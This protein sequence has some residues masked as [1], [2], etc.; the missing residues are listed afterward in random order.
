MEQYLFAFLDGIWGVLLDLAPALLLGLVLAGLLHAFVPARLIQRHMSGSGLRDVVRAV[1]VGVPLPLC[2][3]GVVPTTLGLRQQGASRGAATGFLISTPS[4][5]V[6]SILVSASFLGWPFAIFKVLSAFVTGVLGG[7]LVNL[8]EPAA[9]AT[10][11]GGGGSAGEAPAGPAC[12]NTPRPSTFPGRI[13][14]ALRYGLFDILGA[15]NTYLVV[16]LVLAALLGMWL[17]TNYFHDIAWVQGIGGM[18]LML[19]IATPLYICTTASVPVAASL[20]AAGMPVGT[21]L[22]FLMAGPA[23]NITTL[24]LVWRALGRRVTLIYLGVVVV[25]SVLLG[26]LFSALF[27]LAPASGGEPACHTERSLLDIASA[28]IL[29]VLS[30]YL[31]ARSAWQRLTR[32]A[33]V[34]MS[35][36]DLVLQVGG[37]T[38]HHCTANVKRTLEA[39]P[40]VREAL[41]DLATGRVLVRGEALDAADLTRKIRELGYSCEPG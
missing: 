19:A 13:V 8:T 18:L 27:S 37:M 17:P 1:L 21:A 10:G 29:V 20:V 26:L 28:L 38:C 33:E 23:T 7:W 41:P 15:I 22:V 25:M 11:Q 5:G 35:G 4:T 24:L 6:D 34:T 30:L 9:Q 32:P 31:F 36:N 39:S 14:E 2:S 3:C 12:V 16:G 40:G